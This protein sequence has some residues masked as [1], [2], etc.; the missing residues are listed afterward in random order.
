MCINLFSSSS[1]FKCS[2]YH[3]NWVVIPL[4][5]LLHGVIS[6]SVDTYNFGRP[7]KWNL[8]HYLL[9]CSLSNEFHLSHLTGVVA[10]FD[11]I[12][13]GFSLHFNKVSNDS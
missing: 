11:R 6:V 2:W 4:S 7:V 3:E 8:C 12:L 13:M 1:D 10:E 9:S 5:E